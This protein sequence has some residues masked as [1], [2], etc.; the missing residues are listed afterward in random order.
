MPND[1]HHL[2][3][4]ADLHPSKIDS[5]TG[6]ELTLSSQSLYD[7]RHGFK[8]STTVGAAG[9]RADYV[10]TGTNDQSAI[11]SAFNA[12][13][14]SGGGLLRI[15]PGTYNFDA[16]IV[17]AYGN[18]TVEGSGQGATVL[19]AR[20]AS[21]SPM[22][23]VQKGNATPAHNV[24]FR[25]FSIDLNSNAT[26]GL[27]IGG[28]ASGTAV[29]KNYLIENVEIYSR[30]VDSNGS[31]GAITFKAQYGANTG[32]LQN[33]TLPQ[34]RD[35]RRDRHRRHTLECFMRGVLEQQH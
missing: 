9:A 22:M 16:G 18:V 30:G 24:T 13:G 17:F 10:C 4:S 1:Y 34:C 8:L 20:Y 25:N 27:Q 15:L 21:A 7:T 33:I 26:P 19:R 28:V 6:T 23:A 32:P 29:S 31:Y 3:T 12:L 11:L 35:S 5:T 14:A 2:L